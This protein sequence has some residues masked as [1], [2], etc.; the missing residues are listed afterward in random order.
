VSYEIRDEFGYRD[1]GR[2]RPRSRDTGP[3][4]PPLPLADEVIITSPVTGW[5]THI[6]RADAIRRGLP[7]KE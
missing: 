3:P 7:F 6:L 1:D 5:P 2:G 4:S